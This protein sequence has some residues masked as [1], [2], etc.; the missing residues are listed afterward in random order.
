METNNIQKLVLTFL[1]SIGVAKR[2]DDGGI[3]YLTIPPEERGFFNGFDEYAFTFER[4]KAEK[5]RELELICEGSYLLRKIIERVSAIPKV[6]R[7]Y[8]NFE[9]EL[10]HTEPGKPGELR[11]LTPGTVYYRQKVQFSFRVGFQC[12]HRLD[13]LLT[14]VADPACPEIEFCEGSVGVDPARFSETPSASIPIEES[15]EEILRLY[16]RA[17]RKLEEQLKPEVDTLKEQLQHDFLEERGKV[18][19]FLNEQKQ[20]LQKKKENVCFHL[21]FFQK[22]EEIDKMIRDLEGDH[23]RKIQELEEKFSLKVDVQLLNAVVLCI[24]TLGVSAGYLTKRRREFLGNPTNRGMSDG[25]EA[26]PAV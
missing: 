1:D 18:E 8:G 22:E 15:G 3:W 19:A 7:L 14:M 16:L 5:H 2:V 17:C 24:P 6:S 12:D 26:L 11:V 20:E 10:P 9:P 23:Q 13:R 25:C 4:E 21:Y